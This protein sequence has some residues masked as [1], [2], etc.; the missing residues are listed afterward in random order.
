M[1]FIPWRVRVQAAK[2]WRDSLISRRIQSHVLQD[3]INAFG[4][5][6]WN[7][8]ARLKD[9]DELSQDQMSGMVTSTITYTFSVSSHV[10]N[11]EAAFLALLKEP[12]DSTVGIRS[13][14]R[15]MCG[16][17]RCWS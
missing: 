16:A 13:T 1:P 6:G 9:E 8:P 11:S 2:N 3:G 4:L 14:S 12:Q 7:H 15:M 10:F 5:E 17:R